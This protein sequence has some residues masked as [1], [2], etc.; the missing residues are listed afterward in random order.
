MKNASLNILTPEK[1]KKKEKPVG[2]GEGG[3]G[4]T[5]PLLYH[6]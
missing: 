4:V 6:L 1:K 3:G 5:S 2:K